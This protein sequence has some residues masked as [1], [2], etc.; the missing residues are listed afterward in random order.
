M[1][2]L[3]YEAFGATDVGIQKKVN[4]DSFVYRI[5]EANGFP[6]GIFAIADGV[7]GLANGEVA[8]SV[9]ISYINKWWENDL[10]S[11]FSNLDYLIKSLI[12][13]VKITN[14]KIRKLSNAKSIKMATTICILFLYKDTY[15][16]FNVG[17][18]R[19]YKINSLFRVKTEQLTLD[20]SQTIDKVQNGR[21]V[22]KSVLTQYLGSNDDFEYYCTTAKLKKNDYFMLC[23]DGIYKTQTDDAI[24]GIFKKNLNEISK[25]GSDLIEH[26]KANKENDNISIIV[27]KITC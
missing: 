24:G 2:Q 3:K 27:V 22:R 18:S 13:T 12:E 16:V 14:S 23:S 1:K 21:I 8:S 5:A 26:A 6:C 15:F 4:E 20:H 10:K 17:D 11:Y 25:I 9:A 19:I 7:G